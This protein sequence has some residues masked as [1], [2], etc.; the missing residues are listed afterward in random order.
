MIRPT[1]AAS[2]DTEDQIVQCLK[3][4][5]ELMISEKKDGI[6]AIVW[7]G[8]LHSREAKPIPN[9]HLQEYFRFLPEGLDGELMFW[10]DNQN[11]N[12]PPLEH[13]NSIVTSR[14]TKWPKRWTP[15]FHAFDYQ[16][17]GGPF[18]YR[19]EFLKEH[20]D[21]DSGLY[22]QPQ[23]IVDN[24]ISIISFFKAVTDKRG[25][26]ICLRNPNSLYKQ[27][28]STLNDGCLMRFKKLMK[29]T[30]TI[31]GLT[32]LLKHKGQQ[33]RNAFG[34]AKRDS[35][36]SNLQ[37]EKLLGALIGVCEFGTVKVGSGFTAKQREFF[38]Q[39]GDNLLDL[40]FEFEYRDLT[41]KGVPRNPT[42]VRML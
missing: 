25:E 7:R 1:L 18:R 11:G 36:L 29:G 28:R 24:L 35:K 27:G 41:H 4:F 3:Q 32:N 10:I 38:W 2:I 33:D 8:K 37:A 16:L 26:G 14:D 13:I 15:V 17:L 23:I 39:M 5:G 31:T 40:E 6:R 19:Y 30:A 42:F 34:L 20:Q 9:K 22:I 12:H 21:R